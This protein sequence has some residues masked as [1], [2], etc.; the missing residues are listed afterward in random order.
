MLHGGTG[1]LHEAN[2]TFHRLPEI[3]IFFSQRN[4]Q[5]VGC[6]MK[7]KYLALVMS[8]AA[9]N[10]AFG[11]W[12]SVVGETSTVEGYDRYWFS[13]RRGDTQYLV[14][15][16]E[17]EVRATLSV[18]GFSPALAAN[19]DAGQIYTYGSFYT[20]GNY[21]DRSDWV[22]IY[23][24]ATTIQVGEVEIPP[25]S[26]GIGNPG[27]IGLIRD[28]F[29]G[30]WNITPATSV[31]IVDP[32]NQSFVTE[33]SLPGC[34]GINPQANGWITVCGDGTAQYIELNASGEEARRMTSAPFFDVF[35]DPVYDYAQPAQDGWMYMSFD[36][37]L[38]KVTLGSNSV[39]V[40]E[41]FNINPESDGVADINGVVPR[42]DDNWRIGGYQPFAYHDGESLL[43]TL[44][45]EGGGQETFEKPGTEL[46]GF[47]MLTGKR[48]Y[49]LS[50]GEGVV[51]R[52]ILMTP[53]DDPLLL[54]SVDDGVQ[55]RD[56]RSG[57]LLRT[58]DTI[59]GGT[60]QSLYEGLGRD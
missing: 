37:L 15:A 20:R 14:D 19:M 9:T 11:Q 35:E 31:S 54:V 41:P 30:V 58:V 27:M 40:S 22:L 36:G 21:G 17:G 55:I 1:V 13:V 51:A 25:R 5:T 48:G 38:R 53:G 57:R 44:M 45:H 47:N 7:M 43:V 28:R 29:V 32:R 46:W 56:P 3:D 33:I 42:N 34:S 12:D 8:L 59:S 10:T 39:V 4:S 16:E 24:A 26:A 52:Q 18:S 6:P 60:L 49:R 23:D 2:R 50:L